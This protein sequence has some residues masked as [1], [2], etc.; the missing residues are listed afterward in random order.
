MQIDVHAATDPGRLRERNEDSFGIDKKS[1]LVVVCDGMGGHRRGDVASQTAVAVI[2]SVFSDAEK[3]RQS[4]RFEGQSEL[5]VD[6]QLL[7]HAVKTANSHL[8]ELSKN[9][10]VLKKMGT[11]VVALLLKDGFFVAVHAGDS[12]IYRLRNG[13]LQQLTKDHSLDETHSHGKRRHLITRA[14]GMEPSVRPDVLVNEL[15]EN[16]RF[17]L[18]SDGLSNYVR[19]HILLEVL[20]ENKSNKAASKKMI[21]AA[22]ANGGRDNITAALATV[23]QVTNHS[24]GGFP[25]Q[26]KIVQLGETLTSAQ[27]FSSVTGARSSHAPTAANAPAHLK[28]KANNKSRKVLMVAAYLVLAISITAFLFQK[29]ISQMMRG[30]SGRPDAAKSQ[31]LQ[32]K[33]ILLVCTDE[34]FKKNAV[35][36]LDGDLLGNLEALADEISVLGGEHILSIESPDLATPLS[37]KFDT[38]KHP[39]ETVYT[40]SIDNILKQNAQKQ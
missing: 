2:E 32:E 26:Q 23:T 36:Y 28:T 31:V 8:Y 10:Q 37:V 6:A 18:C 21:A 20:L 22:N 25:R 14:L 27:G 19:R 33:K 34:T 24:A 38:E 5:P 35:I 17:L 4:V 1:G 11:T 30:F 9:Q 3:S 40:I 13:N 7:V 29:E 12:R 16:D 39:G 15:R